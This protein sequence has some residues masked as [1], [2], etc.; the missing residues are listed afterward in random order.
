[1]ILA[2][3]FSFTACEEDS[4]L[5]F[6]DNANSE[7]TFTNSFLSEYILTFETSSNLGERFTW[8]TPDF[9]L[10]TAISYDLQKSLT[11]DFSDYEVVGSTT[12]NEIAITIGDLL[13]YANDL[14]LDND[15][16]T[17]APDTGT[18]SF[19]IRGYSGVDGVE[20]LSDPVALTLYLPEVAEGAVCEFDQLYGVGSGLTQTGW[21]WDNPPLF[22]CAGTGV[23]KANVHLSAYTG[24]DD[25]NFRFF[26]APSDWG[27]GRNYP[28]YADNGYTIDAGFEN[29]MDGDSNFRFIGTDGQY[30]LTIDDANKTITLEEPAAIGVCEFDALFAVGAAITQTGW[31][32]GNAPEFYCD[33]NGV[34]GIY[35]ELSAYT[36]NDD[37][38]FRFFTA[39]SDWGSGRNYPWYA[40]AGY[41][42]DSRFENAMDGDSNFRF[43]GADGFYYLSVDDVNKTITLFPSD[44]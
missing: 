37:G 26:T 17:E 21:T 32:W 44:G 12:G 25:G 14:G 39:A 6:I 10:P 36:G 20:V 5:L 18:V 4:E 28:W 23:Y 2:V 31:D 27:S 1:M 16:G 8:N 9:G 43:T 3:A 15:P 41:T 19:R 33:G 35:L 42:I 29:A 30:L 7:I 38:N 22:I 34:Y 24:N 40:D 13:D 11:G